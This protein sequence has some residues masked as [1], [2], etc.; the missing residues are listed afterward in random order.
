MSDIRSG[1]SSSLQSYLNSLCVPCGSTNTLG[2]TPFLFASC[3]NS[4]HAAPFMWGEIGDGVFE[5]H[6][7]VEVGR[8]DN[9]NQ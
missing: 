7:G 5:P 1:P 4:V 2:I 9:A 8:I 3:T 6:P